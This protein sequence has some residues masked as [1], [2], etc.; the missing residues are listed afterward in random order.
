MI[1]VD[2]L[3]ALLE[4]PESEHL[5]FKEG[6]NRFD[7]EELAKYCCALANEGGGKI[8]F[9]VTDKRPRTVV[10]TKAFKNLERHKSWLL[11]RLGVK[12]EAEA[13]GHPYGDV[14]VVDIPSRPRGRPI[15]CNGAYLMRAGEALAPMP[16]DVLKRI[17][18]EDVFDFSATVCPQARMKDLDVAAIEEFRQ[19]WATKARNPRL[20]HTSTKKLLTDA[21]LV[22]DGGMTYA[23]L[24]PLGTEKALS[25]F[26]GQAE[27]IF[28][29]RSSESSVNY[30]Q[31]ECYRKGLLLFYD[32]LW[33]LINLRNDLYHY[34]D[35]L[36]MRDIPAFNETVA[37]EALLNAVSHRDY[38]SQSSIFVRQYPDRILM[39]SP[40]GLPETVTV[41][42]ILDSQV[43]R[44]RRLA[45]VLERCGLV[46]RSGQG[47]DRMFEECIRE[48]KRV[49][50]FS[51]TTQSRVSVT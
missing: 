47:I 21:E 1:T 29:Y 34:Q 10:G 7:M 48:S 5:E 9:G 49:P 37:R 19:R 43:P 23:A 39:T 6:K 11:D 18:A 4:A 31:R 46:E 27:V 8:V 25:Q 14:V 35:G 40:G 3:N 17:I 42:N 50:D 2:E 13:I 24:I 16:V 33:K 32:D 20:L 15:H 22:V 41:D 30:Q 26:L 12:V 36:F 44:N 45:E 28:E 38:Y 51:G